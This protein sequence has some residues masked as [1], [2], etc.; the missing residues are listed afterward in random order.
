MPIGRNR[1]FA[2]LLF[3]SSFAHADEAADIAT[4]RTLGIQGIVLAD[5]GRCALAIE[6]L[7]R[8]EKLHH[9][10]TTATRLGEC[11]IEQGS[12][13]RGT[14]RLQRVVHET[15]PPDAHPAFVAAVAR[16][17]TI[18]EKNLHRLATVRVAIAAP[19]CPHP[20]FTLD[21]EPVPEAA[22]EGGRLMDPGSHR[23]HVSAPGCYPV[24]TPFAIGE[25]QERLVQV[26]LREDP[27]ARTRRAEGNTAEPGRGP[28]VPAIAALSVGALGL[29]LGVTGGIVVASRS[30]TLS[31][32]CVHQVCPPN[33]QSDIGA[34]KTWATLSTIG[35]VVAAV[36]SAAGVTLLLTSHKDGD[37]R[38]TNETRAVVGLGT[39]GLQGKF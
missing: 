26:A 38:T 15:L 21:G 4:A 30:S 12:L 11:E 37:G 31:Q 1:L 14:E 29:A 18:L 6:K 34:A 5:S 27:A 2:G 16:A 36:G 9:A 20:S 28:N 17:R 22:M 25:G 3:A 13:V 7:S 19:K 10:P 39:V 32:T 8:A 33:A 23:L 35:F 24:E